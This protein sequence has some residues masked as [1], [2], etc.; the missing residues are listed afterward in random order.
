M[1]ELEARIK[2]LDA[3][4]RSAE[5]G[6]RGPRMTI[7]VIDRSALPGRSDRVSFGVVAIETPL[8]DEPRVPESSVHSAGQFAEA[9][10]V[11][12][13]TMMLSV[14]EATVASQERCCQIKHL[15][16]HCCR[17]GMAIGATERPSVI[18]VYFRPRSLGPSRE[19]GASAARRSTA[20]GLPRRASG[21]HATQNRS[22]KSPT[23]PPGISQRAILA[24]P[25]LLSNNRRAHS[26]GVSRRIEE[27]AAAPNT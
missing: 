7:L 4:S 2:Q 10:G 25:R 26:V 13:S 3:A 27:C 21:G 18:G 6:R 23:I 17:L 8:R 20:M 22:G 11:N 5:R 16:T 1:S 15:A 9:S 12:V 14:W 24:R 19:R